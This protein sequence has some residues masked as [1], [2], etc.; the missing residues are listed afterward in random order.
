MSPQLVLTIIGAVNVLMGIAIY[1]G[2]E[3]I[4]TGDAFSSYLINNASIKVGVYM[5]EALASS[6]IA[7]GFVALLSRNL[8][9]GSAKKLLFAIGVAYVVNLTSVLL[10]ILNPEVN[11]PIPAVIIVL[12]LA[13]LA[14]YTS[15]V[16]D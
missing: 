15:K 2:A 7:F 13:G 11:P 5:H 4:V 3:S 10:H 12:I 1:I 8:E 6:M 9:N 14:F 16:A